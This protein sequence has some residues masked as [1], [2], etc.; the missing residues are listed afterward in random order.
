MVANK[1]LQACTS[2]FVV[3]GPRRA[4]H[5]YCLLCVSDEYGAWTNK[6]LASGAMIDPDRRCMFVLCE[7]ENVCPCILS[8][9]CFAGVFCVD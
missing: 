4:P 7:P 6:D 1:L 5:A 3:P 8:G 2:I 9:G